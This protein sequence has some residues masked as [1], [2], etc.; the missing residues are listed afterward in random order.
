[1]A[2]AAEGASAGGDD[3]GDGGGAALSPALEDG[4]L[5]AEIGERGA[6]AKPPA[7]SY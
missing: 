5:T 1:M 7:D 2:G 3:G 4:G 6:V